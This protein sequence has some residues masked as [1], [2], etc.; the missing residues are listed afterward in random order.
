M[1]DFPFI[2]KMPNELIVAGGIRTALFDKRVLIPLAQLPEWVVRETGEALA[3]SR[4]PD[5]V[6]AGWFPVLASEFVDV[7]EGFPF[8]APSR[9][10]LFLKLEREGVTAA[11]LEAFA[12]V[13]EGVIDDVLIDDEMPYEDDDLKLLQAVQR[14]LLAALRSE[15][16][17]PETN[18]PESAGA[19]LSHGQHVKLTTL[20]I[21][22]SEL[23][24]RTLDHHA[25]NGGIEALAP[26]V[27]VC[28]RRK[29]M[30]TRHQH[31]AV[32]LYMVQRDRAQLGAGYS[33]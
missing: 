26:E 19:I 25:A 15:L 12:A 31:E 18:L 11:E 29:A 17:R 1:F 5:L 24:L 21:A 4:I 27:Q 33:L 6:R 23:M 28:L 14:N 2:E 32:R 9:V 10:G 30:R 16:A 8:Y 3:E 20:R 7:A 13:E 22:G